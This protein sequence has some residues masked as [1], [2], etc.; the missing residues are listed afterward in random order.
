[1]P[2]TITKAQRSLN[3]SHIKGKDT[4]PETKVRKYLFRKGFRYRKNVK[5]LK[6]HP[7][8]VFAK[9]KTVIFINGCFWH[10]HDC[11]KFRW[12]KSNEE[13][14]RPKILR[15]VERD[16]DDKNV[17]Q[18]A[19]WNVLTIWECELTKDLFEETMNRL[20]SEIKKG[21]TEDE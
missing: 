20:E 8:I 18:K 3:M 1:M 7:D 21:E 14:W 2:D 11:G 10:M 12:P 19:G 13:Y 9:Y 4:S 15:N 16:R 17:L 5:K 6:G